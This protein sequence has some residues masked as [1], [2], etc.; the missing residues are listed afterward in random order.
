MMEDN[1]EDKMLTIIKEFVKKVRFKDRQDI[2]F[3]NCHCGVL[4]QGYEELKTFGINVIDERTEHKYYYFFCMYA[5]EFNTL[6]SDMSLGHLDFEQ[7][8]AIPLYPTFIVSL[9]H[10]GERVLHSI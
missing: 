8:S 1:M 7:T 5:D 9:K 4:G 3:G 2:K 10:E 6:D